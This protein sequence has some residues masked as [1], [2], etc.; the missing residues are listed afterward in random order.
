MLV[1]TTLEDYMVFIL[2]KT[3]DEIAN[4]PDGSTER[5]GLGR[6]AQVPFSDDEAVLI[7]RE[8]TGDG[9]VANVSARPIR[10]TYWLPK[11]DNEIVTG[12][13]RVGPNSDQLLPM[14]IKELG[15]SRGMI[16]AFEC[17]RRLY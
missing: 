16:W 2:N 15:V 17:G 7:T 10:I 13:Y 1:F 5:I 11:K 14:T 9:Y 4:L 12:Y 6:S 3:K 8:T